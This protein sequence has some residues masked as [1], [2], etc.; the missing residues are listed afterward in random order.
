M[1]SCKK[2][3]TLIE[4]IISM[5]IMGIVL[6]AIYSLFF[7]NYKTLNTV[8]SGVEL[9][10][11][12]EEAMNH[13]VDTALSANKVNYIKDGNGNDITEFNGLDRKR[14]SE[15]SFTTV[16]LNKE[17]NV[18]DDYIEKFTLQ[19]DS[20]NK[21]S[22]T[23]GLYKIYCTEEEKD[24][25]K[26]TVFVASFISS[27][28]VTPFAED[29]RSLIKVEDIKGIEFTITLKKWKS[30]KTGRAEDLMIKTISNKVNFRN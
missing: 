5:A 13:L 18:V 19:I 12:G 28:E 10:S 11:Q 15:I 9:Q 14:I 16:K 6:V 21:I 30:G 20:D 25:A 27:I 17:T 29:S 24:G 8:N 4:V 26:K 23:E 7:S 2:G 22:D 3:F 1:K